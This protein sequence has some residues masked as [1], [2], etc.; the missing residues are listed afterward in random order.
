MVESS[1]ELR[2]NRAMST[3]WAALYQQPHG[4]AI[5]NSNKNKKNITQIYIMI[6]IDLNPTSRWNYIL[7]IGLG[8]KIVKDLDF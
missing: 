3:D 1:A 4:N 2:L 7:E 6:T 8:F 5:K